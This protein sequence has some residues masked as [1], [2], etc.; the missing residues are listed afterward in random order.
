MVRIV[1]KMPPAVDQLMLEMQHRRVS[2]EGKEGGGVESID[3]KI[4][5]ISLSGKFFLEVEKKI[6]T[7]EFFPDQFQFWYF[8]VSFFC[9]CA[10]FGYL[11]FSYFQMNQN[12]VQ[13][14]ITA[15]LWHHFHQ[16]Y[17]MR[18]DL[19]RKPRS[20]VKFANH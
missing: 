18:Q 3:W 20:W 1:R 4:W 6:I 12:W 19:N 16:V 10:T 2:E 17:W 13:K 7:G 9:W 11:Y 15:W 5:I 8:Y 14:S